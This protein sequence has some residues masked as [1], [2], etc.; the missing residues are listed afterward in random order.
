MGTTASSS[1]AGG[2]EGE[3]ALQHSRACNEPAMSPGPGWEWEAERREEGVSLGGAELLQTLAQ[4]NP[5]ALL[6][7]PGFLSSPLNPVAG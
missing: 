3:A 6:Q 1:A 4:R 2:K 7:A 5:T